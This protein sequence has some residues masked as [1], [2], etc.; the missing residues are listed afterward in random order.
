LVVYVPLSEGFGL[1]VVE[2]MAAG[3]PVVSSDVPSA[4]GASLLVDPLEPDDIAAGI[5]AAALDDGCRGALRAAGLARASSLT[6]RRT[7][8]QH[9][10]L[11]RRLIAAGP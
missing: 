6:W 11:W 5:V 10:S 4:G 1:P 8:E 7:A 9:V 3:T 2:A